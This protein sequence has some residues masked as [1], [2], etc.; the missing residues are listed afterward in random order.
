MAETLVYVCLYVCV[1]VCVFVCLLS[2]V[3]CVCTNSR[4]SLLYVRMYGTDSAEC[5]QA[6]VQA[7]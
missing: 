1:C 3:Q 5:A 2:V 6:R 7:E 4:W